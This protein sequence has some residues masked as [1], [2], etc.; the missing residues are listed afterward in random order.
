MLLFCNRKQTIR[1]WGVFQSIF[2]CEIGVP[3]GK[4]NVTHKK[5]NVKLFTKKTQFVHK[6]LTIIG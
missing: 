4:I 5:N 3:Q 2:I 1:K 6:L